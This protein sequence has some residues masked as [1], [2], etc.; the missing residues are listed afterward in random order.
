MKYVEESFFCEVK[1]EVQNY[2]LMDKLTLALLVF[3]ICLNK[4]QRCH[5]NLDDL[6]I[7]A[8]YFIFEKPKTI[9]NSTVLDD[10]KYVQVFLMDFWSIGVTLFL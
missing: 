3:L 7:S 10:L 1:T 4:T 8:E 2:V 5:K 6:K 9:H